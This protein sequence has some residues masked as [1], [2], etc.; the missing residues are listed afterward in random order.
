MEYVTNQ[1]VPKVG[2]IILNWNNWQETLRC[3]EYIHTCLN[4]SPEIW[5]VDNG[6]QDE[7]VARLSGI[8]GIHFLPLDGN[9]GF[10]G[11]NNIGIQAALEQNCDFIL[12]LNNDTEF[13]DDF[14]RPLLEPFELDPHAGITC[15]KILYQEPQHTIWYAGGRFRQPRIL[16]ELVGM[17]TPN[18]HHD[19]QMRTTDFA[20]G[21]CMLIKR[22][23]FTRI[24]MLDDRF[25][26][27]H[28]DVDFSYRA[29]QAGFTIWYQPKSTIIHRV[30]ASTSNR[31]DQ[32]VYLYERARIVFLLKHIRG[33]KIPLVIM[34]EIIRFFR[35]VIN[36][37]IH[38]QMRLTHSY[39][40]GL[41][42]GLKDS[43][44]IFL[45]PK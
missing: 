33:F 6:S 29:N 45:K 26:F 10:A 23:V 35:A 7:S 17:G 14:L 4:P 15:P 20:V 3:L 11:G 44:L 2:L 42:A 34:M 31:P 27:F 5:V 43:R 19:D 28:E 21:T 39:I 25:F 24:G 36:G 41:F 13:S 12:L 18:Q 38:Q 1:P 32:R 8:I 16:G 9:L 40:K 22:D 30:S 37:I